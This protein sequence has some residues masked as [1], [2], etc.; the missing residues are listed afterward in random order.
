MHLHGSRKSLPS[1]GATLHYSQSKLSQLFQCNFCLTW[2]IL[3]D[4]SQ[5][6][7]DFMTFLWFDKM[8]AGNSTSPS[9]ERGNSETQVKITQPTQIQWAQTS[10]SNTNLSSHCLLI[11]I[12]FPSWLPRSRG[13]KLPRVWPVLGP[14]SSR[15]TCS[16]ILI[17]K[18]QLA[19][20][21]LDHIYPSLSFSSFPPHAKPL[22]PQE[23]YGV[24]FFCQTITWC[25]Q[26]SCIYGWLLKKIS[27][28]LTT[29]NIHK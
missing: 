22:T 10:F 23:L 18:A 6:P 1:S 4:L 11:T 2:F 14:T 17:K 7:S 3:D 8:H 25:S 12:L 28:K 20:L 26:C 15:T 5:K 19:L 13:V 21:L 29:F 9:D 27:S 24:S 16:C